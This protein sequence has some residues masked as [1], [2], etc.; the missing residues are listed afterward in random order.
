MLYILLLP[1]F[2]GKVKLIYIDPPYNTGNDGFAYNDNFNHSSWLVF[3]RNRLELAKKI[4]SSNGTI[5]ISIDHNEVSYL[6]LLLDE[7][8]GKENRKNIVT[9]K[10][11]S[12]TGV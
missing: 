3:M 12:V 9:V 7:I 1:Q 10:R 8:F 11:G 2:E 4:L 5:A 6:I